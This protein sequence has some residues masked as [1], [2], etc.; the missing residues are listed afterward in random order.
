MDTTDLEA[1]CRNVLAVAKR[2]EHRDAGSDADWGASEVLA[3]LIAA[4]RN[5]TELAAVVLAG[6]ESAPF[7]NRGALQRP[8][9][10]AIAN[11]AGG[12]EGLIAEFERSTRELVATAGALP[13]YASRTPIDA[14][15]WE[16]DGVV[17]EGRIPLEQLFTILRGHLDGHA[18][19]LEALTKTPAA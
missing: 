17:F 5:V 13:G 19:Q 2:Q 18:Q 14:T 7:T 6:A 15:I 11:A 12:L 1:A 4:N 16:S 3:H 9:L 10:R 8:Y